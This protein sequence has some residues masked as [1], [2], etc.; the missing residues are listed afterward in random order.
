MGKKILLA[1]IAIFIVLQFFRPAKNN[2]STEG[3]ADITHFVTVPDDVMNILKKSCY[4]CHSN[5]TE[6]PWYAQIN[7][8]SWWLNNHIKDGKRAIN[9]SDLS[10][11]TKKKIDHRLG[12]I[13]ETTEAHDMPLSSYTLIHRDAKLSDEEIRI[14]K[15][16]TESA[17]KQ[18]NFKAEPAG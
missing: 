18:I 6:Y 16:W 4:D 10:G 5:H 1:V 15:N 2:G 11:F 12:D 17:K 9:F 13:R 7:P 14:I 3:P 8:V